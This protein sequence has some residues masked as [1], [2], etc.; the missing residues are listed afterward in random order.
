MCKTKS[1]CVVRRAALDSMKA[2]YAGRNRHPLVIRGARQV[3]KSTL[4]HD[5]ARAEGLVLREINLYR[6]LDLIAAFRSLDPKRICR[7]ISDKLSADVTRPG[8][9]L[10]LDELQAIPES[11]DAL[12][13]F[14][15]EMPQ[16]PVV[17]AGS[18]LEFA[19]ASHRFSM[20][21]G[22]V[23]Y[24]FLGPTTFI[25]FLAEEDAYLAG[26]VDRERIVAGLSE[27]AHRRLM[28]AV[29]RYMLVGGMPEATQVWLD[30]H[31]MAEVV[32]VHRRIVN[33]YIDDFAKYANGADLA[34]MQNVFRALPMHVGEK[35]KYVNFSRDCK[36]A[37]VAM[38]IDLFVKARIA[39]PVVHSDS[40]EIPLGAEEDPSVRKLLYLDVGL[41]NYANGMTWT[42]MSSLDDVTLVNEG[43]VAEQFVGQHLF[44]GRG[45]FEEPRLNY[46]LRE[47]AKNNAEVDYVIDR[48]TEVLPVEVKAG[49]SGSLKALRQMMID[50]RLTRA[51]RFDAGRF[52]RQFVRI[53]D[54]GGYDLET[55]PLYAV[56]LFRQSG[57]G[58]V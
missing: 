51:V 4:V 29:R 45:D 20:P 6:N 14:Y 28:E 46:W 34:L 50:K 27:T 44:F 11:I 53:A 57:N 5:F 2:W 22:R 15:E 17:S 52:S 10:F 38:V 3:G 32:K 47:G 58:S 56:S 41:L 54:E 24:M 23:E 19:L 36:A 40:N 18:L 43:V 7:E 1:G 39:Y 49:A 12:R 42:R 16:L 9:L 35:V 21:V 37:K 48:E 8:C 30:T 25:E 26:M 33:T 31:D 55:L 13:Y